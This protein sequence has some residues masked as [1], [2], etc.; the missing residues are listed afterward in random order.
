M[1]AQKHFDV[2]KHMSSIKG[3]TQIER[4]VFLQSPDQESSEAKKFSTSLLY[5]ATN[6]EPYSPPKNS[7]CVHETKTVSIPNRDITGCANNRKRIDST[8][9]IT[10]IGDES[11]ARLDRVE[12]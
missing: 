2:D 5:E 11:L 1:R 3:M 12:A 7:Q 8:P 6:N 9:G 4:G 10:Q